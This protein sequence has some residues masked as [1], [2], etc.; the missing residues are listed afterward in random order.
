MDGT[1]Y[2][3]ASKQEMFPA[4]K[5][6]HLAG[7]CQFYFL[8]IFQFHGIFMLISLEKFEFIHF[9]RRFFFLFMGVVIWKILPNHVAN[10]K[11][12]IKF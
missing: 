6:L 10:N 12:Y 9:L 2:K 5:I 8:I 3:L 7:G 1:E 11:N 4:K